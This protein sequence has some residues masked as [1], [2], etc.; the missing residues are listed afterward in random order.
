MQTLIYLESRPGDIRSPRYL[1]ARS[2]PPRK[3]RVLLEPKILSETLGLQ[4]HRHARHLGLTTPFDPLLISFT[5]FDHK[6][7]SQL[8]IGTLR[9]VCDNETFIM[10]RDDTTQD[11]AEDAE[12]LDAIE[13]IVSPHGPSL[14]DLY[15]RVVH[16]C[17][18]IIQKH[19]FLQRVRNGDMNFAPALLA[20][21]Y[22]L[23]LNWWTYDDKLAH[24]A[25]PDINQLDAIA[26]RSLVVAMQRPK[27]STV[28]A[29]LL[30]LQRPEKDS[31]NLTT[32]L[33]AVGQE[34][35]LHL[36]CTAWEIPAW[37][38]GLRKRIAWALYMQDKWSS[39]IHGRPSHIFMANWAVK[40]LVEE[41]STVDRQVSPHI[42]ETE[43]DERTLEE[44]R[45]LFSKMIELTAIMSE[46]VD[47]FYTQVAIQ[48]FA[49]AGHKSTQMI[50][51]RAKPVQIKLKEWF[52]NL[53]TSA[54]MDTV[55]P[56]VLAP[57]GKFLLLS[58]I[59][60]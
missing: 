39:L 18:P 37:E 12:S 4:S 21:I 27:L 46:V 10:Q 54:R 25:R 55:T 47:T 1:H 59:R 33:V 44:G 31:W 51:E 57:A 24:Q 40:P 56:G 6:N 38:K 19:V 30:L 42:S 15:F 60:L 43:Q 23:A 28:Q 20:G 16:P 35:G 22:M 52:G 13:R 5:N 3:H 8:P 41:D 53:P 29:G 32:Q 11:Y 36:D 7:E 17:F 34:I 9:R 45:V 48:E 14:I 50:L 2:G 58:F 49:A 26:T